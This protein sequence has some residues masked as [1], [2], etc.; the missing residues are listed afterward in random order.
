[1]FFED[2]EDDVLAVTLLQGNFFEG[3]GG[4]NLHAGYLLSWLRREHHLLLIVQKAR[5]ELIQ[6]RFD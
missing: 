4:H 3:F 6:V 1:M 5:N 2:F